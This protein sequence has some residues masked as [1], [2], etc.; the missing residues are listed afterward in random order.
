MLDDMRHGHLRL[1]FNPFEPTAT[2]KPHHGPLEP[3]G[4]TGTKFQAVLDQLATSA[5]TKAIVVRGEYGAGKTC[6]LRWLH[7]VV[8]PRRRIKSFYFR[9]PGVHFY[10]LADSLLRTVGRKDFAKFIWEL[11]HAHIKM[12]HQQGDLFAK[13]FESFVFTTRTRDERAKITNALQQAIKRSKVTRDDEIANCLA[14]IVTTTVTKPYFEYRDFVPTS[15]SSVV[16]EQ[17]EPAF[18]STLLKT[19]ASGYNLESLA[20]VV[21]EFEEISLQRRLSRKAAHDYLT[22][23]KRLIELTEGG[24]TDI[25][26]FQMWLILSMTPDAYDKTVALQPALKDRFADVIT[27]PPLDSES[28]R[29]LVQSRLSAAR[30]GYATDSLFPFPAEL[31]DESRS[32]LSAKTFSVARR[33][34]K[35]CF[36]AIESATVDTKLPFSETYLQSIEQQLYGSTTAF[37]Q[38]Q[39]HE[40]L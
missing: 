32:F 30:G 15:R 2:G 4:I 20:F 26:N 35:T 18:F 36:R 22:T 3:L 17:E 25:P 29:I 12:P 14:R 37:D 40:Q 10:R 28:A 11:A 23:L 38:E 1:A 7:E 9:D 27:I 33:L 8:F 34:V 39:Q 6:L 19:L 5:G 31:T 16:P 24:S 21:D 13:G